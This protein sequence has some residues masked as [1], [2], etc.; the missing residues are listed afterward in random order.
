MPDNWIRDIL[1][2]LTM[3][4]DSAIEIP[5]RLLIVAVWFAGFYSMRTGFTRRRQTSIALAVV[6]ATAALGLG[7]RVAW[8]ADDA[9]ISFRYAKHL[10]DGY[11][12]IWNVGERVEGTP[13]FNGRCSSRPVNTCSF[14]RPTCHSL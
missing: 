13:T 14:P 4:S 2:R 11:G 1:S 9:N 6:T 7:W 12:L 10:A 5:V 3:T 8:M